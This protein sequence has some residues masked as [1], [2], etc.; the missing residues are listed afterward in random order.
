MK[1]TG[2][3]SDPFIIESLADMNTITSNDTRSY[4][5]GCDIDCNNTTQTFQTR[6][7]RGVF[8]G[9]GHKIFNVKITKNTSRGLFSSLYANT[10]DVIVKNVHIVVGTVTVGSATSGVDFGGLFSYV[11]SSGAKVFVDKCSVTYPST[12]TRQNPISIDTNSEYGAIKAGGLIG[13]INANPSNDNN[14]VTISNCSVYNFH[15]T[16]SSS[17]SSPSVN[18]LASA[19]GLIGSNYQ[20]QYCGQGK[21]YSNEKV[22]IMKCFA[23]G[24]VRAS[25]TSSSFANYNMLDAFMGTAGSGS[26][27]LANYSGNYYTSDYTVAKS[28][29]AINKMGTRVVTADMGNQA[30]YPE[31]DF[32][33]DWE[34][35]DGHP[36]PKYQSA[37][38]IDSRDVSSYVQTVQAD[39]DTAKICKIEV[40]STVKTATSSVSITKK[41]KNLVNSVVDKISTLVT[42]KAES[43]RR[44]ESTV[45]KCTSTTTAN[46]CTSAYREVDSK[47]LSIYTVTD[48]TKQ[49]KIVTESGVV[50]RLQVIVSAVTKR[51]TNSFVNKGT[52]VVSADGLSANSRKVTS[53]VGRIYAE[54]SMMLPNDFTVSTN[55]SAEQN[56]S[57]VGTILPVEN[58]IIKATVC[59]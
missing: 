4:E 59:V 26:D 44:T 7:F 27:T 49:A 20:G 31:L 23:Q 5:L 3:S 57:V 40:K 52:V 12:V 11:T 42:S 48:S 19:G 16:V 51:A 54:S 1:G 47:V 55:C 46:M 24:S 56:G 33:S 32:T 37:G 8:N 30:S 41:A 25:A 13:Y 6:G 36:Q 38:V 15:I 28:T 39:V 29:T 17:Y 45:Q 18:S 34:M 58:V 10:T 53:K 43:V 21:S 35:V 2:T 22:T 50:S 14:G 9:K